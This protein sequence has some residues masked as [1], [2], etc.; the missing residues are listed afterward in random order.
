MV[1][2]TYW[3]FKN[4]LQQKAVP[5]ICFKTR[6][7][8]F[9]TLVLWAFEALIENQ[10]LDREFEKFGQVFKNLAEVIKNLGRVFTFYRA[11]GVPISH[12]KNY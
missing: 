1:L 12:G 11:Q 7:Q 4:S 8:V 3:I 2:F 6:G 10:K 9:Q 5:S